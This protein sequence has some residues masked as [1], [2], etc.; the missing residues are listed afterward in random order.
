M[1]QVIRHLFGHLGVAGPCQKRNPHRFTY[2]TTFAFHTQALNL[3]FP[4]SQAQTVCSFRMEKL[5]INYTHPEL[6][7]VP[8]TELPPEPNLHLGFESLY[9]V[10][11]ELRQLPLR[12]QV[13]GSQ[14]ESRSPLSPRPKLHVTPE[15]EQLGKIVTITETAEG[16]GLQG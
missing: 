14:E 11:S 4:P 2:E 6:P 5:H 8:Y 9:G 1:D 15:Q 7:E 16:T 13:L 3:S 10:L 12:M